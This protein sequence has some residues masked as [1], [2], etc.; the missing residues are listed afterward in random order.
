MNFESLLKENSDPP[1]RPTE[2]TQPRKSRR[3]DH[4]EAL[5][6]NAYAEA[7]ETLKPCTHGK[8]SYVL[9]RNYVATIRLNSQHLLWKLELGWCLHPSLQSQ[10]D[11]AHSASSNTLEAPTLTVMPP[12]EHQI[13]LASRADPFRIADLATGTAVWALDIAQDFPRA[14]IDGF[15]IDLQQC[16]P[17]EWL[18]HNVTI[19]EWNIFSDL[20]PELEGLYDVV[21]IRLLLL[22]IRENNPRAVLKN[23][24]RM[25]KAGGSLQWDEL[26]PWGAYTV[27]AGKEQQ[28]DES[29]SGFQR[30]QELTAMDTL[31]WVLELHSIM[32]EVGFEDVRREEVACDLRLAKYYQ[33][34]QFLVLEE[35]A[36]N[37]ATPEEKER[38]EEAIREGVRESRGG[39][40][41]VTPKVICLGRKPGHAVQ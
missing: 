19:R 17:P 4:N 2:S 7:S 23:A 27:V 32:A 15:D 40:A 1:E 10:M 35:E 34:M 25:L 18:P 21:H 20:A 30:K 39:R 14:K 24:L 16:P 33:D 3:I 8:N 36:A 13:P 28:G 37:K 9:N 6:H 31:K 22:V 26:D 12:T 29:G 5:P 11:T 41:R 38:V